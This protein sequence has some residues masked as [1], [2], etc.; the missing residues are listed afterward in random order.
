MLPTNFKRLALALVTPAAGFGI[1]VALSQATKAQ[2]PANLRN[3]ALQR[4]AKISGRSVSQLNVVNS[5][6]TQYRLQGKTVFDFKVMDEAGAIYGITLNS[7]GQ[8]VSS[9]QLRTNEQ[10]ALAAQYGK[11][12]PS[13]AQKLNSAP[14]NQP[15]RVIIWLKESSQAGASRPAP[16]ANSASLASEA[17]V[18]A[19]FEQV[20]A[21]RAA[22]VEPVVTP[23]ASKLRNLGTNVST[24]KY[25]PV[26]YASLTPNTI[27]Q[28]GGW[29]EVLQVYEEQK[30]QPAL[31]VARPTI[32]ADTV[33]SRGF[34]G[35]GVQVA[36]IE[37]GGR[38]ATSNPYLSGTLQDTTYVCSSPSG[39]ST[40]VAGIIRSTPPTVRGIAPGVSLWAGGSCSGSISEVQNRSTAAADWGA[41][42][43]NLSLGVLDGNLTPSGFDRFYDDMVIN[44]F[45][46][47]VIAAGNRGGAGC[48]QGTDGRVT[49]PGL[50]YNVITV[51]NFNDN[52][53]TSW[54]G[55]VMASC[56][57][58]V[59]PTSTHSDREKPEVAAPGT[60]INSTTT[61][62]PWTGGIGSGTSYAA[63]MV[64]GVAALLIQRN[65]SLA[66]WPEAIKAILMTTA[67]H[68]IEGDARLSERDGAG[69]IAADRADDVARGVNG[70]WGAESYSCS[71]PTAHDVATISLTGG[72]RT[73]A[74]IA[75]DND[76]NYS[77]YASQ[78]GADLDFQVVNSSNVVVASSASYD[79]TYEIVDFTPSTTG[80]YKLRVNKYRC[81]YSPRWL[82]WAWRKGN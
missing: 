70:N 56:S 63:P 82:G 42:A 40:G 10:A 43:L 31:E 49:S 22:A 54:S 78:P 26:V 67:I 37:V 59:D 45:R 36:Q 38:I 61:A 14:A 8:E 68:N 6:E 81:D 1:L 34:T 73:R 60:N 53:T 71:T 52:N 28:V 21:K 51:G 77:S 62:S 15:M 25:A 27:R 58:Y 57:S 5:A 17:Q 46:T 72:Q 13:L 65:S 19:F 80:S 9:A 74:T 69:G 66:S 4:A 35:T 16:N 41:R 64:T 44:R 32:L 18:N 79:N 3:V 12:D 50:A 11:L 55:D 39:H 75:W 24:D 48:A 76:P 29:S 2:A 7:S 23:V 33:H 30:A 20:D 47:V